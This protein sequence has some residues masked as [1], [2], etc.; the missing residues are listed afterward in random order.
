[1]NNDNDKNGNKIRRKKVSSSSSSNKPV[2]RN[3]AN[4]THSTKSKKKSKKSDKF[5]K[6]RV[7]GIVFLVLLVVG[8]AG[9]AGLVFASLRDVS[10]VTEAV[11]DKQTN[12]TTTIKY[13]N[14]KTLSTAPSVN[15]KTP[16]PL[17]KIST[18][19][20]H[21]VIAIEDERFYEHKGVDIKGLFRSVLKTLTGTKQ[22]G[23]TI[24]MQVSKMLLTTEQQTLPRK[25]K[26]IYYAYEMSK[27]VSKDKILETYLN[28]FFVGRGLAGAEAGAR[29][30]F[31]KSAADLTIAE[32][33]LLAGSTKNPSRF[34]AYK[35]SKLDGNETKS[36]LE[37]KLLFFVNTT[38]DNLDDPTQVDFDMI[39]K[40]KT[41][42]LISN[43]TYRQ[44]KAGTL[45]VRKAVSN[46]E[47]KK[48]QEV[49]LKKMLDLG[50]IKQKEYDEAIN[51]K[52]EIK[53]PKSADKVSSSVEDLIESEV[54]NALM[55]QGHTN[56][57][58]QN[59]FYNGG[60]IVNTTIDPKM[61][62]ALEE[63]FDKNSNFPGHM[64]GPDGVSQ[65]QSAMVILDYKNGEIRA[66]A[67]GRNISGRKTL[68]RA[69][70]PHQP[71][72]SIKPL[73]IYTPA[74]D[75]LKITQS[76]ALND[77]RGGYKFEENTKWNPRTTTSGHGSMSLRKALAKSSNTIAVKTAEML[78]DS[79]DEC[80]DI[81]MD[82]LK[83]FGITT[84]KN[85][86][87]GATDRQFPALTL[88]GM[89]SGITPLQMAAAYGTLANQGVYVEPS[90]Y[91]TITTFDGQ[92]LVKNAPEEHKVVDPE[93]AYVVTDMLESVITEGTGGIASLPKGMPVAGKTG[94]TNSAYDAWFVGYTPYYVG[95]TYIGDD[96]GRKDDAGNTIKRRDVPHGSTSTAKLW[97]KIMAKIH[98]NLTVTEFEVPKNVYFTKINLEDGGK[99][100]SGSKAA[101]IEGTAPSRVSSQPSPEDTKKPDNNQQEEE[102]NNNN[103][104]SG[105]NGGGSTPPDN[106]GNS[107]GTTPPPD[108]GGNSGGTTNPP[109]NG[110][111]SDGT[112]N[113][114]DNGGNSGGTVTPPD[115]GGNTTP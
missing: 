16:V 25:I 4:K 110:G 9:T 107:G 42:E 24:P 47:A 96:A 76:T 99:Q 80:I 26:D 5:K 82:Y 21:A 55:E 58:A 63:E 28:N 94:T 30:Y 2:N 79:Y 98:A 14:G 88:G 32:S 54:I 53:L 41:W 10:P 56:D 3:S 50:Y 92:L 77:V 20:Q 103:N 93:V 114:P 45:V 37:N 90:I 67:G 27:T 85:S 34:S 73:A 115:G 59:L 61:Q 66:L 13:A 86:Q 17:D 109:D 65:P 8:A 36:D 89:A 91:T 39:E 18:H 48:R 87:T 12:Q 105:N 11:L 51:A 6:L 29:G 15:K 113:P 43:D 101:F 49:V 60:L 35:T 38:D 78:G 81:M 102:N 75:T 108:N 95:A 64:V 68:N 40:L 19:L 62:D 100:S 83:N 22:G 111:N 112:T 33:A 1:M 57:E 23:S 31:D 46:P 84:V 7:F 74:I 70:S 97:Q 69:T 72:S 44:L 104:N 52:I 71:G 106:G